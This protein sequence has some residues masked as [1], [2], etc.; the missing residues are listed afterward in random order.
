MAGLCAA[1][2]QYAVTTAPSGDVVL[3][4]DVECPEQTHKLDLG[5]FRAAL[6]EAGLSSFPVYFRVKYVGRGNEVRSV[7]LD[8]SV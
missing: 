3:Y 5:C 4:L 7:I 8:Q 6:M 1:D 2:V